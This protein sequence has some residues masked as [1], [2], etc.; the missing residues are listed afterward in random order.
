MAEQSPVLEFAVA[1]ASNMTSG[2]LFNCFDVTRMRLQIQ[3]GLG[4]PNKYTSM[5]HCLATIAAEEGILGLWTPG[6]GA[7][8]ARELFYGGLQFGAYGPIKRLIGGDDTLGRKTAA[9][10]GCGAIGSLVGCP[11]DVIKVRLQCESGRVDPSTGK[12]AT[13]LYIGKTPTY[14]HSVDA[15]RKIFAAEG[16]VGFYRGVGPTV[17]RA[18]ALTSGL[19]VSYDSFKQA[20]KERG[21]AEEGFGLHVAGLSPLLPFG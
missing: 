8:I 11:I 18:V 21:L 1:A 16:V 9:A 14:R 19:L 4:Q 20:V 13:G 6:L 7:A 5:R 2:A 12:F 10:C 15:A 17:V 3:H